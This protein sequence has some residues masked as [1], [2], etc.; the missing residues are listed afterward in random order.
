MLDLLLSGDTRTRDEVLLDLSNKICHQGT[1][2]SASAATVPFLFELLKTP[3]YSEKAE[4]IGF[5]LGLA[6]GLNE[7]V[8]P[9]MINRPKREDW[10]NLIDFQ[11][12]S[13]EDFETK[14]SKEEIVLEDDAI[15]ALAKLWEW[16][17][18][19]AVALRAET[20]CE[21]VS[22]ESDSSLKRTAVYA[23]AHFPEIAGKSLPFLR[24][25]LKTEQTAI[26]HLNL[27]FA[28]AILDRVQNDY[29]DVREIQ[30]YFEQIEDDIV[31]IASAIALATIQDRDVSDTVFSYLLNY[32]DCVEQRL[33]LNPLY[34]WNEGDMAGIVA[35]IFKYIGQGREAVVI[36][37]LASAIQKI[38][39]GP[40]FRLAYAFLNLMFKSNPDGK[41]RP[42]TELSSIEK[43]YLEGFINSDHYRFWMGYG[44]PKQ[45]NDLRRWSNVP[46]RL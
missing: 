14:W 26:D 31:K 36:P 24:A 19:E 8:P 16:N 6:F 3:A 33:D 13:A 32:L 4:I 22:L 9:E 10:E 2:Y 30:V 46:D 42:L 39:P 34:L 43:D 45:S 28:L 41:I 23:L 20:F 5:L 37:V 12:L 35:N 7:L 40:E 18:Y 15:N 17:A 27:L 11:G 29:T 44:L 25:S 1:R 38:P 21:F